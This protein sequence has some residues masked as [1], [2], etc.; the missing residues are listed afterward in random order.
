MDNKVFF[1]DITERDTDLA[2]IRSF[3]DYQSV[4]QLFF[5]QIKRQG[6][7]V[8]VY[9]SLMQRESDGH[10]GESDI[11]IICQDGDKKFAIFIEDKIAADPQ[12]SQR[13]RYDDRAMLLMNTEGYD[14]Y[15]VFL[16]AP[17]VYI[18]TAKA[19]GYTYSVSH[20]EI[21]NQLDDKDMSKS[22]FNFSCDEK[23]QGYNPIKNDSVT[24]FWL[25]LYRHIGEKY[26]QLKINKIDSP[27]GTNA[28]WPLFRTSVTGLRICWKSN[29]EKNC[30]DMEF[31]GMASH[32]DEFNKII[33]DIGATN[34]EPV[35]TG[36]SMS[37]TV[38]FPDSEHVS[39]GRP[40]NE[41]LDN[42]NKFLDVVNDF[43]NLANK[44][45]YLGIVDL[46]NIKS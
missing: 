14:K 5:V 13:K 38:R 30:V 2:I 9:H 20:Q 37:L 6:E 40:F 10:S 41:Q 33:K 22:I 4:R 18:G 7:V 35:Q 24:E 31:A 23:K 19:D 11:V 42:I 34:Y 36:K 8:K 25:N 12:P 39:F 21:C 43:D 28:V 45:Y 3:L 32:K 1:S 29:L 26:P 27:R 17:E 46:W 16:C 15:Y 44:I